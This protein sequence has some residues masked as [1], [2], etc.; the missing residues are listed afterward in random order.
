[1]SIAMRFVLITLAWPVLVSGQTYSLNM[2][3]LSA[4]STSGNQYGYT[5]EQDSTQLFSGAPTF[6]GT[7]VSVYSSNVQWYSSAESVASPASLPT[8]FQSLSTTTYSSF[9]K[10]SHM[11]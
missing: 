2:Y 5:L 3:Q 1:M 8:S 11:E 10:V 7:T 4:A 9:Y 6:S